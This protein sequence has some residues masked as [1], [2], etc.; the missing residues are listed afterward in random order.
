MKL[1]PATECLLLLLLCSI[2]CASESPAEETTAVVV[3]P[4]EAISSARTIM[5]TPQQDHGQKTCEVNPSPIYQASPGQLWCFCSDGGDPFTLKT[6][7]ELDHNHLKWF[8]FVEDLE[9][10]DTRKEVTR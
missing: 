8:L 10:L 5:A 2:A 9:H 7:A 4:C 6:G 3:S 1:P